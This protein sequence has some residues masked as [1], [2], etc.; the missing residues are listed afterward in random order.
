[1]RDRDWM[2]AIWSPLPILVE[3]FQ[4]HTRK[5]LGVEFKIRACSQTDA[6]QKTA[7]ILQQHHGNFLR[8]ANGHYEVRYSA[9]RNVK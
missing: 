4:T 9:L 6:E 1:M 8:K 3:C 2:K 7:Q 5:P